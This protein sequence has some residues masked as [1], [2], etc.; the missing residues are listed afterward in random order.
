MTLRVALASV[1]TRSFIEEFR[2][3]KFSCELLHRQQFRW[4]VR[5]DEA[6][7]FVLSKDPDVVVARFSPPQ[8]H[9][10]S[11]GDADFIQVA[12]QKAEALADAWQAGTSGG[13]AFLD[14]DLIFTSALLRELERFETDLI[15]TPNH[16]A[17]GIEV[18]EPFHGYFNS[19]FVLTRTPKFHEMWKARLRSQSW[20]FTDQV[21]LNEI[22]ANFSV[23][24]LD[25]S[26]NVGFWHSLKADTFRFETIP[27]ECSLLHVHCLQTVAAR[28]GWRDRMFAL[29]CLKFLKASQI[30]EHRLLLEEILL[31]DE[32]G[33]FRS[34][35]G[36]DV[37]ACE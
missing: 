16:H 36:L 33:W 30:L 10:V 27:A 26:V 28:R 15:L 23:T 25:S 5:C 20:H 22:C 17:P 2:L 35:L 34:S 8:M 13:V 37:D 11:P 29:H 14:A 24:C 9:R 7:A 3:L 19:G 21:C 18:L 12:L 4:Y 6:A 31:R 1:V 32:S